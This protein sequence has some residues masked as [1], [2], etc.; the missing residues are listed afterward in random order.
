MRRRDFITFLGSAAMAWPLAAR[1]QPPVMP[2]IG[3]LNGQSLAN[4]T[5]LVTAFRRGL[6]EIGYNEGLNTAIEFRW[7]EGQM[8]RLPVLASD[9]VRRQVAVIVATGG[10]HLVA[11]A[12]TATIPIVCTIGGGDPVKLGLVASFSRPG[13]NLT[14]ISIFTTDLEAK[15]LELLH[16]LLP[17]AAAFAVLLD[18][19]FPEAA[20]Q[21]HE[22]QT[23]ARTIGCQIHIVNASTESDIEKAFITVLELRAAGIVVAGNP[24]FNSGRNQIIGLAAR[25]AVPAI[26]EYREAP[27]SGGLMSYGPNIPEMYRQV[28]IYTGRILKGEKPADLPVLQPA[29]FDTAVNLRT[30]KA[31]GLN[32]PTSLLLRATEVIE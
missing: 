9:L 4:F 21:V 27:A 32:V 7:A 26:Y 16:E 18:P 25:H 30:A 23:A 31:L 12:A 14:G 5:H 13:G 2:V 29:K 10:A 20:G 22:V 28:G 1:A 6:N 11:K 3:F 19:N 24:F 8:E 17:Q 15:R